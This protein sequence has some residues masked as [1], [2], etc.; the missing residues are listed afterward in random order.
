MASREI[1]TGEQQFVVVSLP[2]PL[3][4]IIFQ[5][6]SCSVAQDDFDLETFLLCALLCVLG[7]YICS[8]IPSQFRIVLCR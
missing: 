7:L 8:M 3:F 5:D 6:G 1:V 4:F 2:H